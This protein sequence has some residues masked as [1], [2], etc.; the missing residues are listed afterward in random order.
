MQRLAF[1]LVFVA[2]F[3]CAL[4]GLAATQQPVRRAFGEILLDQIDAPA[5]TD[6]R[7]ARFVVARGESASEVAEKLEA[8]GLIRSAF[9]FRAYVRLN[10]IGG[11][12]EAG[13]YLLR[14]NM[15]LSEIASTLQQSSAQ[16]VVITIP[17]G[18]RA[19]EVAD[20][21]GAKNIV[22]REAFMAVV[23][24]DQ[25]ANEFTFLQGAGSLEGYLFPDT[26]RLL[27]GTPAPEIARRILRNF[28]ERVPPSMLARGSAVGLTPHQVI[29]LASV[30]EREA[31][32]PDERPRI[33]GVYVNRLKRGMRL[34]ADP[35]VQYAQAGLAP[36]SGRVYWRPLT[37]A[38]LN[39]ESPYNTYLNSGL[40]PGPI[41]N[42]GLPSIEAALNPEEHD[43]LYFVARPDSSHVFART[44]DEH[45]RNVAQ[46]E[47]EGAAQ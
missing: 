2:L 35:T 16:G 5:S 40:P 41:C 24:D 23:Q 37:G 3:S 30:V 26:Y 1:A 38:D 34:Q 20:A 33:A 17:E 21:L 19:A 27:P 4:I 46:M 9:W 22:E 13:E 28:A 10:N 36:P 42:P 7:P 11:R 47:R 31:V 12:I 44:L 14:P 6:D 8:A 45:N 29:V 39:I 15:R 25:L 32:H 43:Y 18:W